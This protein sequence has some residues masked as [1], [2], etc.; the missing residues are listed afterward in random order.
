MDSGG[1]RYFRDVA[2][3]RLPPVVMPNHVLAIFRPRTAMPTII[4][5]LD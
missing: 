3:S 5:W 2:L 4:R 1:D